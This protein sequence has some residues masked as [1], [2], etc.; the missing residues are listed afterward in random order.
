MRPKRM[1]LV[2]GRGRVLSYTALDEV[3]GSLTAQEIPERAKDW[4]MAMY[5]GM[6]S[7]VFDEFAR[8][9]DGTR[10]DVPM[11]ERLIAAANEIEAERRRSPS[12]GSIWYSAMRVA[13]ALFEEP[14]GVEV[15]GM[16][17]ASDTIRQLWHWMTGDEYGWIKSE[18]VP[19]T[20]GESSRYWVTTEYDPWAPK[21]C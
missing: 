13:K 12:D 16:S 18:Y 7:T 4:L 20:G 9:L 11:R 8:I 19:D 6:P 2:V 15:V 14:N 10:D 3:G 17:A 5:Y 1:H 21:K